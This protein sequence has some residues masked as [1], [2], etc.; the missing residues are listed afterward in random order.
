[1]RLDKF[2]TET[3]TASRKEASSL[4]RQGKITVN[5]CVVKDVSRHIIP[6]TDSV[7]VSD[8]PVI[9]KKHEY[10]MLNKPEGYVSATDDRNMPTV[11]ELLPEKIRTGLFPCGRLDRYTVGMMILTDDGD[12]AH[13]LLSPKRHAE[14]EYLFKCERP[15]SDSD[16]IK[17]ESGVYIE[18]GYLTKPCKVR[19]QSEQSA[20]ITLTEG[21]Y[22]QIK[23]ML[24]GVGNRVSY[25]ERISFAGIPLDPA[26]S[27]GEWRYLTDDEIDILKKAGS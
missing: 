8:R 2:L 4:A 19:K 20:V 25:L 11:L 9:Y 7:C 6:E 10:I 14:K 15:L 13:R 27:R 16:I 18:G 5:G 21:K 1:M 22:H 26:L 24:G 23:Q 12:L 17:L 3:K